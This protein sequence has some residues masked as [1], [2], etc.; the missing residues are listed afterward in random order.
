MGNLASPAR[1]A[2]RRFELPKFLDAGVL[3]DSEGRRVS[4]SQL[5]VADG[6]QERVGASVAASQP[7]WYAIHTRSQHEKAVVSH[8]KSEGIETFLPL[9]S[10]IHRWSDR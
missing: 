1:M 8:L 6:R 3:C 9:V 2:G 10:E 5:G 4:S 7:Q